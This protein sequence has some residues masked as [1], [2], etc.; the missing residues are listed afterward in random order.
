[1]L[2]IFIVSRLQLKLLADAFAFHAVSVLLVAFVRLALM[3]AE[4][5]LE[6]ETMSAVRWAALR[7]FLSATLSIDKRWWRKAHRRSFP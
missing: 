3:L 1:V 5:Q 4:A 2:Q 6:M 7:H